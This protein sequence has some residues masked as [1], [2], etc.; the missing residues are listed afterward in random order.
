MTNLPVIESA[1]RDFL[2]RENEMHEYLLGLARGHEEGEEQALLRHSKIPHELPEQVWLPGAIGYS[3]QMNIL[4]N[5]RM[6]M[7]IEQIAAATKQMDVGE[8]ASQAFQLYFDTYGDQIPTDSFW[9]RHL[10]FSGYAHTRHTYHVTEE[11]W[12]E[13]SEMEWPSS[14]PARALKHLPLPAFAMR[15]PEND[16]YTVC[17]DLLSGEED[18]GELELRVGMLMRDGRIRPETVLHLG[19]PDKDLTM[20]EAVDSAI[21]LILGSMEDDSTTLSIDDFEESDTEFREHVRAAAE[22]IAN[23]L[24]YLAGEDDVVRRTSSYPQSMTKRHKRGIDEE[25]HD[26][27]RTTPVEADVG[28]R[29]Q[30]ALKRHSKRSRPDS[31]GQGSAKAPHVRRPHPHLYWTGKGRSVPKVRYLGPIAVNADDDLDIPPTQQDVE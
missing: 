1:Y 5:L 15:T 19:H 23:V 27:A 17:Y 24:L 6:G 9:M 28:L 7:D 29:M 25:L 30:R 26:H 2:A 21:E 10:F 8:G 14:T 11:L 31:E 4:S 18:S 16:I 12:N 3:I 20:D 13:L 22:K